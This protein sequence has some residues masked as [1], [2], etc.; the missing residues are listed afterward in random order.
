VCS[1]LENPTHLGVG[2]KHINELQRHAVREKQMASFA[3]EENIVNCKV[4]I[5][6]PNQ[7][8]KLLIEVLQYFNI[9]LYI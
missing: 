3:I 6:S 7:L 1:Y 4:G 8:Y 5:S 9:R 2:G